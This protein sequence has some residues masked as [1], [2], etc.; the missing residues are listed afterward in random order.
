[1]DKKTTN[2][3]L[4][5][6]TRHLLLNGRFVQNNG[7][8]NGKMGISIFFYKHA[9]LS[10]KKVYSQYA[11]DLMD[12][13]WSGTYLEYPLN[14]R[15]GLAGMAWGI[16]YLIQNKYVNAHSD[17]ILEDLDRQLLER[18]VR[19]IS[20]ISLETGLK[21]I[22]YY[23]LC[24]CSN[25]GSQ[26]KAVN[27]NYIIELIYS[28]AKQHPDDEIVSLVKQFDLLLKENIAPTNYDVLER[29]VSGIKFHSNK[30]FDPQRSLGISG[31]G[32]TGIAM[33]LLQQ[34]SV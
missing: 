5:R 7:L 9:R 16:E 32:Y 26:F 13:I 12:D 1:M 23:V 21:G 15:D 17:D 14:F 19:R 8:L 30:V 24:R 29:M 3:I 4:E 33:K 2:P 6:I 18:D 27:R 22:S 28:L 34:Y 31:N 25:A 10:G 20:D 11:G